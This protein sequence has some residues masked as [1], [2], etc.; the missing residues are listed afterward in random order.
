MTEYRGNFND[1]ERAASH[2]VVVRLQMREL[3]IEDGSGKLLAIWPYEKLRAV[4]EMAT[5][6]TARLSCAESPQARLVV[7][8]EVFLGDLA[9]AAP[10]FH[11]RARTLRRL[12]RRGLWAAAGIAAAVAV[13][14]VALP[15][16]VP[17]L[18]RTIPVSW[19]EALGESVLDD[20]LAFFAALEDQDQV[21]TC[22][23]AAGRAALDRL[24]ARLG[25]AMDSPYDYKVVVVDL[26]VTN[27]F[28]LP[29]GYIVLFDGLLDFVKAPEEVAGVLA[30]EMGHVIHRH[31]TQAMLRQMGLTVIFDFLMGG[32]GSI[33]AELGSLVLALSYSREAEL[34]ADGTG[35]EILRE[36]GL[37]P[38]GLAA[39]F[40]R[41][42][43]EA[44]DVTGPFQILSTHPSFA[45]RLDRLKD[46]EDDG[47]AA[48]S[49][50][51]WAALKAICGRDKNDPDKAD[52]DLTDT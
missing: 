9:E 28:A 35:I 44:G 36:A 5:A 8:G 6:K 29:G 33:G 48:M 2:P 15:H 42:Q 34:Q 40:K 17:Y 25:S 49:P 37:R 39:F 16:G 38:I 45:A 7:E 10:Q 24:V 47:E 41:L 23:A 13:F 51:E 19:E 14:W 52:D 30:H 32:G 1:G 3:W 26:D 21:R 31:G 46:V 4:D 20:L 43:G 27:A 12:M 11:R 18:A 50:G 22:E